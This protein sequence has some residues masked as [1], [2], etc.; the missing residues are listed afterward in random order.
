MCSLILILLPLITLIIGFAAG[1]YFNASKST[2]PATATAA[3]AIND[4][5]AE[6]AIS[7]EEAK[8]LVDTFG[9]KGLDDADNRPGGKGPK[10]RSIFLPLK[11]LDSLIAALD[12]ARANDGKTR[13][14]HPFRNTIIL[15]STRDTA[16][17]IKGTTQP[18]N[19]HLDYFGDPT[20]PK[21]IQTFAIAPQNR[22]EMC[23]DN[24]NGA[25]LV[26]PD[27]TDPN[28]GN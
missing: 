13:Y 1:Y 15:V 24:C 9:T 20:N 3:L 26:C 4:Y 11:K 14:Q 17:I 7:L 22:G 28:C 27:P 16:V 21:K 25:I 19:I 18:V 6:N 10:T 2:A 5:H 23:P 8:L 12:A